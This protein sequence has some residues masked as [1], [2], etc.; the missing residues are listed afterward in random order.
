MGENSFSKCPFEHSP[1]LSLRLAGNKILEEE[2]QDWRLSRSVLDKIHSAS[3]CLANVLAFPQGDV[4]HGMSLS[5]PSMS[6][7]EWMSRQSW[8]TSRTICSWLCLR[9]AWVQAFTRDLLRVEFGGPDS[10]T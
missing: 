10:S 3:E 2:S 5:Q 1:K 7:L 9:V 4:P 6:L 8:W